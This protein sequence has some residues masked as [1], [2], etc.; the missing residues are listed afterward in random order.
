MS[1][2]LRRLMQWGRA[3]GPVAAVLR[4]SNGRFLAV[5]GGLVAIWFS[6]VFAFNAL[7]DPLALT[8]WDLRIRGF[9]AVK[10]EQLGWDPLFK[11]YQVI[12]RR[13]DLVVLG[14][15]RAEQGIDPAGPLPWEVLAPYNLGVIGANMEMIYDYWRSVV[16][17]SPRIRTVIVMLDFFAFNARKPVWSSFD[18][19]LVNRR[20][21]PVDEFGAMM[22]S[23]KMTRHSWRTVRKNLSGDAHP[24]S[25]VDALGVVRYRPRAGVTPLGDAVQADDPDAAARRRFEAAV[26]FFA[27]DPTLLNCFVLSEAALGRLGDLVREAE[28]LG[29][30]VVLATSPSH[31]SLYETIEAMGLWPLWEEWKRRLGAIAPFWDFAT[32]N[33]VTMEA[34]GAERRY[35]FEA[36]HYTPAVGAMV[37]GRMF[38]TPEAQVPADFGRRVGADEMDRHLASVREGRRAWLERR[39][40]FAATVRGWLGDVAPCRA[41]TRLRSEADRD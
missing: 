12:Y 40:A 7:V 24:D 1:A 33:S 5:A 3:V 19:E 13:P 37:L 26:R 36:A 38:A 16:R 18:K 28:R 20:L 8:P 30:E 27:K 32:Y 9:N 15:S 25:A 31:A 4:P 11:Y 34:I 35:Y 29:V 2:R 17:W 14:S 23:R 21:F 10:T 39:P 22:I 41:A 6:S